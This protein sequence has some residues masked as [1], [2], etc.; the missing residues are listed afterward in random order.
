VALFE[1]IGHEPSVVEQIL[2]SR[3]IS[4]EWQLV[5]IDAMLDGD[6]SVD[7]LRGLLKTA[8]SAEMRLRMDLTALGT[9]PAAPVDRA[10]LQDHLE[11]LQQAEETAVLGQ[12]TAQE[13]LKASAAPAETSAP[14]P[15][16]AGFLVA[17]GEDS[18]A[19]V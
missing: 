4:L 16:S 14:A 18:D 9:R 11:H 6:V 5:Q 17:S 19:G 8:H 2:I 15:A 1:H 12:G 13:R 7:Q 10:T 3:I